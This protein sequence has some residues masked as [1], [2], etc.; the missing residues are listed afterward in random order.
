[1]M[2][3]LVF[4]SAPVLAQEIPTKHTIA[5]PV[6]LQKHI[7]LMTEEEKIESRKYGSIMIQPAERD[8]IMA[9]WEANRNAPPPEPSPEAIEKE[10]LRFKLT[11]Q[12]LDAARARLLAR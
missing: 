4:I 7:D 9:R 10:A 6:R 5:T 12:E 11:P 2:I 1:M 3:L 8:R